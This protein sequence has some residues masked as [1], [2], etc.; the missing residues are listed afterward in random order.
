VLDERDFPALFGITE[1]SGAPVDARFALLDGALDERLV[2]SVYV[3]AFVAGECLMARLDCGDWLL[4]GGTREPG[5]G[6]LAALE[7]ELLE[8][9]GARLL[10]YTPFALLD[11][12]SRAEPLRPHLPHPHYQCL[13]GH[14]DVEVVSDPSTPDDGERSVA[15]EVMPEERAIDC[16]A[17]RGQVWEAELH[18]FAAAAKRTDR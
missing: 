6:S 15:V 14:G 18:R 17:N 3:V 8:E 13:L 1:L 5:E 7:R 11:C 16:F 4:L 10:S 9:A 2:A 12:Q